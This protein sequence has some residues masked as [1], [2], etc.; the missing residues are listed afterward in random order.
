LALVIL[1]WTDTVRPAVGW[2]GFAIAC[3]AALLS[4]LPQ[5]STQA[6]N[7]DWAV[8]TRAMV[9]ARD[10]G[11]EVA[12]DHL[13]RGGT[14]FYDGMAFAARRGDELFLAVVTSVPVAELDELRVQRDVKRAQENFQALARL[15]PEVAGVALDR[16]LRISLVSKFGAEGFEICQVA[17]GHVEWKVKGK[18]TRRLA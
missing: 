8:L 5:R 6:Q 11:Y 9:E 12:M 1:S 2:V 15:I 17:D 7:R 18:E 4:F 13:D 10:H 16:K 3:G 14:V